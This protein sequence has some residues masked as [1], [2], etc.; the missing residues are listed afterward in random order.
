MKHYILILAVFLCAGLSSCQ[1][2]DAF[3]ASTEQDRDNDV[4]TGDD[5]TYHLPVIFHVLYQDSKDTLQYIRTSRFSE[6]IRNVNDLYK[7]RFKTDGWGT[8]EDIHVNFELALEDENNNKL[9]TPGVEYIKYSGTYPIDCETF[10][11]DNT[12]ANTKYIW[13]PNEYINVIVYPFAAGKDSQSTTLGI[14]V[15][16]YKH[17]G[18]PNLEGLSESSKGTLSKTNLKFAY[19]VSLNSLYIYHQSSFFYPYSGDGK[20]LT[21]NSMDANITLAHELG[22]YL[23]LYHDFA[24]K[25]GELADSDIDSDYC[26]DTKSYNR[27]TYNK[28]VDQYIQGQK[29]K[30]EQLDLETMLARSNSQGDTWKAINIMDYAITMGYQFTA[31]QRDRIRQVLYYSPLMPGPKKNRSTTKSRA[32]ED[33]SIDGP[34]D[35]P[36]RLAK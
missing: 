27:V 13:D 26:T 15:M 5:Y 32:V 17:D 16:P 7:S 24:E 1:K 4:I 35:L 23:G 34:I 28:W 3:Y 25:D 29:A 30:K 20:N 11:N 31:Q 19:C 2:E 14:S 6:L 10:M 36:I 8:G 21:L 22:H 9:S 33:E 18:Y 12:K